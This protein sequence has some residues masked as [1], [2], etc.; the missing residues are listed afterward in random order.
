[1]TFSIVARDPASGQ[2]GGATQSQAFAVG[3]SVLW[4]APGVG[5]VV[6]QSMGEPMYGELGL[7]G[8]RAG[9]T[10][11]EALTALRAVDPHPERRQVAMVDRSGEVA[12]ATG[13]ACVAAAGHRVGDGVVAAANLMATEGVWDDMVAAYEA[14][15]G[16]LA[17][18][19]LAAMQAAESAGGDL[20][21]RRS[22][23]LHVVCAEPSGRPWRDH[24][25]ELRVDDHP[26]PVAELGRM[27]AYTDRY[28]R[29]A[30]GFERALDGDGAGAAAAVADL[31]L[32]IDGEPELALWRA[33]ILLVDGE[34]A[35]AREVVAALERS[36]PAFVEAARRFG[37]AGLIDPVL[38]TRLLPP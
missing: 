8:L 7:G 11:S 6:T 19:L 10:A 25:V 13:A 36:A 16:D 4:A 31:D 34:E 24:L 29:T 37:P 38:L 3:T 17:V 20:R 27:L 18:R 26:D 5:A 15:E 14:A 2:L 23:A 32:D 28:H 33:V 9:L 1:M 12:V 22:A 21:G 35:A 30:A